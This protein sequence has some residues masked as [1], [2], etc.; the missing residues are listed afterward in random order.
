MK[1]LIIA[2]FGML[3]DG[4]FGNA[5]K[6]VET[7]KECGADAVKFQTHIPEAETLPNAPMP[8]FFKG[9]PR[10]DYFKR[11]G[12]TLEQWDKLKKYCD[13]IGIE[14]MSSP[15]SVE[16][17]ELLE[18]VGMKRYKIP[19]GEVTNLPFL[20]RV[21][22][23]GKPVLLSSGMSSWQELDEA[24]STLRKAGTKDLTVLQC[25]SI[26]P[27]PPEKVGLNVMLEMKKR[28]NCPVGLSDQSLT[29]NS[30]LA[31]VTLGASV[32]EK[33]ITLTKRCYGSDAKHSIEPEEFAELASGIR[34]IE[35]MLENPVDKN[36][37]SAFLEMKRVFEKSVVT[38]IDVPAGAVLTDKMLGIRKPGSG[39]APRRYK[40]LIGRSVKR[41]IKAGQT[42]CD[43]DIQ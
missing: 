29:N 37:L 7:A 27:T 23:T 4:S 43:S 14:F 3:H 35:K 41:E 24:V 17:V 36:D 39:I 33:H 34:E 31:A 1:T 25:T 21:A 30:C 20:E 6:M 2:E 16:A 8:P 15:F 10:W 42:L 5:C 18:R 12:F 9:E 28:Y 40:D 22:K 32:I 13:E 19:S 38:L 11:T 26:Y